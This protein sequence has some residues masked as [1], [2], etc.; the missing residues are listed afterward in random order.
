MT[1]VLLIMTV[2]IHTSCGVM[3][4]IIEDVVH[5][6]STDDSEVLATSRYLGIL[7]ATNA[8]GHF[9]VAAQVHRHNIAQA[10]HTSRNGSSYFTPFLTSAILSQASSGSWSSPT[11][12]P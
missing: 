6:T 4:L 12:A 7:E 1:T 8:N 10:D 3:N 9:S 11:V 5:H 2:M